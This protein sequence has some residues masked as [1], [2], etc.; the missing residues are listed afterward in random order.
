MEK[1]FKVSNRAPYRLARV[2]APRHLG[3]PG[4]KGSKATATQGLSAP[5]KV[6]PSIRLPAQREDR[7]AP[8]TATGADVVSAFRRLKW[9]QVATPARLR[10]FTCELGPRGTNFP[11][12]G[13]VEARQRGCIFRPLTCLL[14]LRFAMRCCCASRAAR[15]CGRSTGSAGR[16][17]DV[18]G[19]RAVA[20][21]P[22]PTPMRI[23]GSC[24]CS[25]TNRWSAQRCGN[26]L[27]VRP[28]AIERGL[29]GVAGDVTLGRIH[30]VNTG[31][32]TWAVVQTPG[33]R[34]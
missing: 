14:I 24:I 25:L 2:N 3:H 1:I 32:V 20:G 22:A 26:I 10:H 9:Q 17:V 29:V 34:D 13:C 33:S 31:E 5:C 12:V 6:R 7:Q 8:A 4:C 23:A 28:A 21:P 18:K 30:M 15:L 11:V 16:T 27:A 19:G